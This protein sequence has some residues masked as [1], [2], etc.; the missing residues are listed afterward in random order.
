MPDR[1]LPPLDLDRHYRQIVQGAID[2]AIIG[3][4][5][6]GRVVSWNEGARR[7]LGWSEQEMAG[8]SLHR[9]FTPEDVAAG[10]VEREMDQARRTGRAADERW[11]QR[12]G[13]ERF[14]ASGELMPLRG[15]TGA[16]T[17]FV[18]ILRDRTQQQQGEERL[19]LLTETLQASEQRLQLALEIGGMGVW[20][21]N[22]PHREVVWWP[23]MAEIH[24][25]APGARPPDTGDYQ[26]LIHPEDRDRVA[27]GVRDTIVQRQGQHIEYRVVWP[28]GSVHW[29]EAR[30]KLF[31]DA[32]GEPS[33]VAGVC[34]DITRRKRVES[35]LRFLAQASAELAGLTDYQG[36]L[37]RIAHL[38]VPEFADWCM[39][40]IL[41]E[42]GALERVAVA[43]RDPRKEQFAREMHRRFPPDPARIAGAGPLHVLRT[44]RAERIAEI[45]DDLLRRAVQQRDYLELLRAMGVRSYI[46]VP[47]A[48]RGRTLGVITFVTAESQRRYEA[49]DLAL[50]EDLA[51]RAAVAIENAML[52]RTVQES[53]RAKDVFLATLAHELRNPLAPV[54]NGLTIIGRAPHDAQRVMQVAGMIE[55]QVGQLVRLVDDLLDVSRITT[56]KIELKKEPADLGSVLRSAIETSRPHIEAARHGLSLVLPDEPVEVDGDPVRLAQ[57]FANLLNNA[58]KYTP[59]GGQI[60]VVV[61]AGPDAVEVRVRD[62]GEGL[63]PDMLTRVFGLFTQVSHPADRHQGGLGIGLS[64]VEGLVRLHGGTVEARSPG[65]GA[66]SEFIVR[67]PRH[68]AVPSGEDDGDTRPQ[69]LQPRAATRPRILVVDDNVDGAATLAELLRMMGCDVNVAN[70][71]TSAVLAV[72]ELRPDVVLLDIGLPDINGYEV[73]RQVRALP[74]VRQP[75]LIALTGWGQEQ[76]KRMA[77][78]AGFDE[79]WTKPVDPSR[80]QQLAGG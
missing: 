32:R 37:D 46:G 33:A 18:K 66:G 80:L 38:A 72:N 4:D 49:Q 74:G 31:V 79:H 3:T 27:Q 23:G 75:R 24:G 17:G 30:S 8:Q 77:A 64:L 11:H 29:V 55:R 44:G 71:G 51:R 61:Q 68:V 67:L 76:D 58:S 1:S 22:L 45:S 53:D 69:P 13:G 21:V 35:D 15:D 41:S 7:I 52:L 10:M 20:Q 56:G 43:H 2:Y 60:D 62:T 6:Q 48:V 70:D 5:E 28:D 14:W 39:V 42:H 34:V 63:A 26:H 78:Q 19:R 65:L 59:P 73:A 50:A 16:V 9:I 57:V 47:L 54:W 12:S 25:M 40:D 36:T